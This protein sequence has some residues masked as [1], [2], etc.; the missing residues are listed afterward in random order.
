MR[1]SSS[2]CRQ[3]RSAWGTYPSNTSRRCG[4]S[5]A[6]RTYQRSLLLPQEHGC[7]CHIQLQGE[8][9]RLEKRAAYCTLSK[10]GCKPRR[11]QAEPLAHPPEL[12][13][14]L[15]QHPLV[16]SLGT[17]HRPL[18]PPLEEIG[19]GLQKAGLEG[20]Q[21]KAPSPKDAHEHEPHRLVNHQRRPH[22]HY[23]QSLALEI[24]PSAVPM[25]QDCLLASDK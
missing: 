6:P 9:E 5:G 14:R 17:S 1:P 4:S 21:G 15:R 12:V 7:V 3:G 25:I 10:G 24:S 8:E 13:A 20:L 23:P 22:V 18:V 19:E 11:V 16:V 2:S